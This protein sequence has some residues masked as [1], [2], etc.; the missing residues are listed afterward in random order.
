[1]SSEGGRLAQRAARPLV[2]ERR[3][4]A[5]AH[6]PGLRVDPLKG[7]ARRRSRPACR[8]RPALRARAVA[9]FQASQQQDG[10]AAPLDDLQDERVVED[11]AAETKGHHE[12][13]Q[14]HA[15]GDP[16]EAGQAAQH[17]D[18]GAG[19]GQE[20]VTRPGRAG[21]DDRE[22]EEG[23][24]L[25]RASSLASRAR[26]D[27][28][29]GSDPR[30][31]R[32]ARVLNVRAARLGAHVARRWRASSCCAPGSAGAPSPGIATTPTPSA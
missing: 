22:D 21:G 7:R 6:E 15:E 16:E 24:G 28:P 10:R 1:M 5:R 3:R 4:R 25:L 27:L 32:P 18:V 31:D 17:A 12:H 11:H 23:D 30:A 14:P 20:R 8:R 26:V 13:H 29:H 2:E 9:I 19:G